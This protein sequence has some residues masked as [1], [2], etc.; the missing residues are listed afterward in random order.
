MGIF[1]TYFIT[2]YESNKPK[3]LG[4]VLNKKELAR[5]QGFENADMYTPQSRTVYD[6]EQLT[7]FKDSF[8]ASRDI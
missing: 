6:F 5:K 4:N 7:I 8:R 3:I 1:Y 2:A